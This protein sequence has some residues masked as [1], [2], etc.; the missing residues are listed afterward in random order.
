MSKPGGGAGAE[1]V[2][3]GKSAAPSVA[4]P[5][6]PGAVGAS[7]PV[8]LTSFSKLVSARRKLVSRTHI[9]VTV[10]GE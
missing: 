9:T 8:A 7:N 6:V 2:A 3:P 5:P 10:N 1:D 4:F